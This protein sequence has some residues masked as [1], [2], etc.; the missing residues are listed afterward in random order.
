MH[1]ILGLDDLV[2]LGFHVL[3]SLDTWHLIEAYCI[4]VL[5]AWGIGKPREFKDTM[6]CYERESKISKSQYNDTWNNHVHTRG[7][8]KIRLREHQ[9]TTL[10][11]PHPL[12]CFSMVGCIKSTKV[13][14][15]DSWIWCGLMIKCH[16]AVG[17][18][19]KIIIHCSI[20]LQNVWFI[21][22]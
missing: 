17:P 12:S 21:L 7:L 2:G 9:V 4:R 10:I 6:S 15:Y 13:R 1:N 16:V 11:Q 20:I 19:T 14:V 5:R 22:R 18:T 8:K 3:S